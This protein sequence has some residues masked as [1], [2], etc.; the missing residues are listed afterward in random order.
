[1]DVSNTPARIWDVETGEELEILEGE[2]GNSLVAAWSPDGRSIAVGYSNMDIRIWDAA[3]VLPMHKY[4][5]HADLIVDLN[6]SPNSQRIASADYGGNILVW[7]AQTGEEVLSPEKR[8]HTI[9]SIN[10]SP[11]G[12]YIIVSSF[13]TL[14]AILHAWQT[15]EALV[16]YAEGCCIWRDLGDSERER[17]GLPQR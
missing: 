8:T 2:S 1:M 4:S 13:D 3:A 7:D 6:W 11:A 5:G 14:P 12:D 15:T 17:F 10:W 9:T 16:A